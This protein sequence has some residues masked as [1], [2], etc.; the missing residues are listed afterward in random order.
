MGFQTQLSTKSNLWSWKDARLHP[1]NVNQY[2]VI[3]IESSL[4]SPTTPLWSPLIPLGTSVAITITT[5]TLTIQDTSDFVLFVMVQYAQPGLSQWS[6]KHHMATEFSFNESLSHYKFICFSMVV[7]GAIHSL[8]TG[9]SMFLFEA[10]GILVTFNA[11]LFHYID[12]HPKSWRNLS[13]PCIYV[14]INVHVY[15]F[16]I[17]THLYENKAPSLVAWASEEQWNSTSGPSPFLG[18]IARQRRLPNP[19]RGAATKRFGKATRTPLWFT[20]F[21]FQRH[22]G[23]ATIMDNLVQSLAYISVLAHVQCCLRCCKWCCE[24]GFRFVT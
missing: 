7:P 3:S 20:F 17:Y 14:Y 22:F 23:D 24:F 15:F 1:T 19:S 11:Q 13:Y 10:K 9:G 5:S 21:L 18:C 16:Y 2:Q 12:L 8:V 6:P 4:F